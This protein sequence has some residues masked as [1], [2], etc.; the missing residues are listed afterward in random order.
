MAKHVTYLQSKLTLRKPSYFILS[1]VFGMAIIASFILFQNSYSCTSQQLT[2]AEQISK[3]E[4]TP[5]PNSCVTLAERIHQFNI[6]CGGNLET[7][8]CG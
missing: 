5:E 6:A 8:D 3:Y 1:V 7:V 4:Q 2:L